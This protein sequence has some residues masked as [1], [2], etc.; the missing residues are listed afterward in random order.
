MEG[1]SVLKKISGSAPAQAAR[2]VHD[3]AV[4]PAGRLRAQELTA[5]GRIILAE[6]W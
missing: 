3:A 2:S 6:S 5:Q 4:T 1:E